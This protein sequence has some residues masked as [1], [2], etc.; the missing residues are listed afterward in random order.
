MRRKRQALFALIAA[1]SFIAL[2]IYLGLFGR[3]GIAIGWIAIVI[4]IVSASLILR[5][6]KC[7]ARLGSVSQNVCT[8]C[9]ELLSDTLVV[10]PNQQGVDPAAAAYMAESRR[11][12]QKW[13]RIR[14]TF[15]WFPYVVG[16]ATMIG[17]IVALPNDEAAGRIGVSAVVGLVGAGIA[18][19]LLTHVVDNAVGLAFL[20]WRGR[21]PLCRA[22]FNPPASFGPGSIEMDFS[23]PHFCAKCGANLG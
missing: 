6:P 5:C 20:A 12:L 1:I 11:K 17:M 7:G 21:C 16:L 9:G 8:S 4:G 3:W 15:R 10:L 14:K 22:W 19:V 23:L 18:W 13:A 2:A